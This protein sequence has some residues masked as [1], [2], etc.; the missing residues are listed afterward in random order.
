MNKDGV[1]D[2][3]GETIHK[4]LILRRGYGQVKNVRAGKILVF[5]VE[6]NSPDD[7][8]S[9]VKEMSFKLRLYNPS[10]HKAEVRLSG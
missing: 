2:P 10:V 7:A 4:Y 5:E 3:E 6:A 9:L 8:L 1:R